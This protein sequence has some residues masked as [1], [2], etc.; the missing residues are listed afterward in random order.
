MTIDNASVPV[1]DRISALEKRVEFLEKERPGRRMRPNVTSQTGVCGI[2]PERD[3]ATCPDASIY[4]YQQGCRGESC[5][6]IH[7]DY[8]ADYRAK[9]RLESSPDVEVNGY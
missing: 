4:R 9:R 7:K 2:V 6:K 3:S 1:E 8:Y 5:V